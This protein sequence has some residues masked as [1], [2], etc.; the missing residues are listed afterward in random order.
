V[1]VGSGVCLVPYVKEH[2]ERYHEWMQSDF[3]LEMT[4]SEPLSIEEEYEMQQSWHLDEDKCTFIVVSKELPAM[5]ERHP[6]GTIV[7]DVNLFFNNE[8]DTHEAEVEVMIADERVRRKGHG[9]ESA[10]LMMQYGITDLGATHYTAKIAMSNTPS[11]TLFKRLGFEIE[12]QS[13]VFKEITLHLSVARGSAGWKYIMEEAGV[14]ST[15]QSFGRDDLV[16]EE[17]TV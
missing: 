5:D 12:S 9:F 8:D 10:V 4:A 7:G 3:L 14:T 15:R 16:E 17:L 13:D 1:L 6:W 11:L 2:V